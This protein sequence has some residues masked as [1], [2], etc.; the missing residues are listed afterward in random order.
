MTRDP[1]DPP[2]QEPGSHPAVD[3]PKVFAMLSDRYGWDPNQIAGLSTP[4]VLHYMRQYNGSGSSSGISIV[5]DADWAALLARN[6]A[7]RAR[8]GV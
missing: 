7:R 4:Q 1:D 3:W 2:D 5:S 8:H 6:Q